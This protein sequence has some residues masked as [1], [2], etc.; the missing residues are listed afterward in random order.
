ML[1]TLHKEDTILAVDQGD[2]GLELWMSERR[3]P[4]LR[5]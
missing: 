2:K 4:E 5:S 3:T 1:R